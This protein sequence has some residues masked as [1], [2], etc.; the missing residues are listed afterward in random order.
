MERKFKIGD[1]VK[2]QNDLYPR[3]ITIGSLGKIVELCGDHAYG[4]AV[5][6][7]GQGDY[8]W[9]YEQS[10][11]EPVEKHLEVD[12]VLEALLKM[13]SL[14]HEPHTIPIHP[15][16][17]PFPGNVWPLFFRGSG[18]ESCCSQILCPPA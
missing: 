4:V 18:V 1:K 12:T 2:V 9:F 5:P 8:G 7:S 11:L 3:T 6:D 17:F 10:D 14:D 13:A 16:I 15:E